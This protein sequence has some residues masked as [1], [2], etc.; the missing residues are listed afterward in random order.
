VP[1]WH[2]QKSNGDRRQRALTSK[3]FL[4][5][6]P[7]M[8]RAPLHPTSSAQPFVFKF[9]VRMGHGSEVWEVV[10]LHTADMSVCFGL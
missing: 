10:L 9:L 6:A 3:A 5:V 2:L 4:H 8:V 1:H 7:E